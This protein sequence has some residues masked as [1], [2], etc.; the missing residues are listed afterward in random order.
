M[1]LIR[2]LQWMLLWISSSMPLVLL[3]SRRW[4]GWEVSEWCWVKARSSGRVCSH[5]K[6]TS[7]CV[8]VCEFTSTL[9]GRWA[10]EETLFCRS[11]TGLQFEVFPFPWAQW[12]EAVLGRAVKARLAR[13]RTAGEAEAAEPST[14]NGAPREGEGRWLQRAWEQGMVGAREGQKRERRE[15]ENARRL[16]MEGGLKTWR[17]RTLCRVRSP[18]WRGENR[19]TCSFHTFDTDER[20]GSEDWCW[21]NALVW[22]RTDTFC[23]DHYS[24]SSRWTT[25]ISVTVESCNNSQA[26]CNH[27]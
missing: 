5:L 18:T 19:W 13:L 2:K 21:K 12:R 15:G 9:T 14:H 20:T 11:W 3:I 22:R 6:Q 27:S 10:E 24:A 4:R 17:E 25:V 26:A 16:K 23:F 7:V 1:K 8:C